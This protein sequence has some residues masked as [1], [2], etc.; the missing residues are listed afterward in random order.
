[1]AKLVFKSTI[2]GPLWSINGRV[3]VEVKKKKL[4]IRP[5]RGKHCNNSDDINWDS[6]LGIHG[7]VNGFRGI[8]EKKLTL[9][10]DW[11]QG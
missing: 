1:M 2:S 9:L 8:I 6:D 5:R 11:I 3:K 7:E 10:I 4:M